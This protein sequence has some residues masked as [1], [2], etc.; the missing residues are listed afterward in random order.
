ARRLFGAGELLHH[1]DAV[2]PDLEGLAGIAA[3]LREAMDQ[4]GP[5][6]RVLVDAV[7]VA[8][9]TARDRDAEPTALVHDS[10]ILGRE[11]VLAVPARGDRREMLLRIGPDLLAE[12]D[13][14]RRG[15]EGRPMVRRA[16]DD[17]HALR[18][19]PFG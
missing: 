17:L 1:R 11:A 5:G 9:E 18:P 13:L 7:A 4:E 2:A 16:P 12:A 14:L 15:R 6:N 10:E 19:A 8:A 3:S